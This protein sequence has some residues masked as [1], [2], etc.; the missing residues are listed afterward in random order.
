M[1]GLVVVL[2]GGGPELRDDGVPE[3]EHPTPYRRFILRF[4]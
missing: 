4:L 1:K 3:Q 2:P